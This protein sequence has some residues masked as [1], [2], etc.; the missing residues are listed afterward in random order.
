MIISSG[1]ALSIFAQVLIVFL[2][3]TMGGF[4]IY[5]YYIYGKKHVKNEN[6]IEAPN[7]GKSQSETLA[8]SAFER[9]LQD[10]GYDHKPLIRNYRPIWLKNPA[11]GRAME[12]DA[13]YPPL[14]LGIEYNGAQHYI[15]PNKFHP[16]TKK[17]KE[18]FDSTVLRDQLKRR[19]AEEQGVRIITI[20]YY[21]DTCVRCEKDPTGHRYK[22]SSNKEKWEKLRTFIDKNFN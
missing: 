8:V 21:V 9:V 12:I 10:K 3:I 5:Y 16:D 4:I 14:R 22:K 15:F 2:F 20:P 6:L 18:D 7:L 13:Y 17:G 19:L 1:S 11:T